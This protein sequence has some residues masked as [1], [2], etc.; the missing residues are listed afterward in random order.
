MSL[1]DITNE[2]PAPSSTRSTK[3]SLRLP[4]EFAATKK[5]DEKASQ[6]ASVRRF[7]GETNVD[8]WLDRGLYPKDPLVGCHPTFRTHPILIKYVGEGERGLLGYCKR[9]DSNHAGASTYFLQ[10]CQVLHI[11]YTNLQQQLH[12]TEKQLKDL[13]EEMKATETEVTKLQIA[14]MHIKAT[15]FGMRERK[16]E[17]SSIENLASNGGTRKKRI[18]ATRYF[19]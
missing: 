1:R 12:S 7:R 3:V 18:T 15:P 19:Y 4:I 6:P 14:M 5:N 8:L 16:R 2:S 10:Q 13:K 9:L 17:F 11:H